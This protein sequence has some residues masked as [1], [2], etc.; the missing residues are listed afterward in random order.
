M[1][2][3]I[4]SEGVDEPTMEARQTMPLD[5]RITLLERGYGFIQ[6]KLDLLLKR[7]ESESKARRMGVVRQW[8]TIGAIIA[9]IIVNI[10]NPMLGERVTAAINNVRETISP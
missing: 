3:R 7:R 9:L 10:I 5:K 6:E 2:A 1:N 8:I 4:T